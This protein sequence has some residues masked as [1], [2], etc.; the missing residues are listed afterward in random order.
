MQVLKNIVFIS[1]LCLGSILP[2]FAEAKA[3]RGQVCAL[4]RSMGLEEIVNSAGVIFKGQLISHSEKQDHNIGLTVRTLKFRV[5]DPIKG[6]KKGEVEFKEWA[7]MA[8]PFLNEIV[9][10]ETYVF[11][12]NTPSSLGLTSLT[13][14][15]QGVISFNEGVPQIKSRVLNASKDLDAKSLQLASSPVPADYKHLKEMLVK[16]MR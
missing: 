11:F 1:I 3:V 10:G 12:L 6:V 5:S 14:L 9:I 2:V 8:S 7:R 4:T 15:E 16:Y 13:G